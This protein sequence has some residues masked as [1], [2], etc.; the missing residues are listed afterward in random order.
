M[1]PKRSTTDPLADMN[2]FNSLIHGIPKDQHI[3][4]SPRARA[5]SDPTSSSSWFDLHLEEEAHFAS[6]AH[7][8]GAVGSLT[9]SWVAFAFQSRFGFDPFQEPSKDE[10]QHKSKHHE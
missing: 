5:S 10:Q 3:T 7:L 2:I 4:G 8:V 1:I 6:P 9:R